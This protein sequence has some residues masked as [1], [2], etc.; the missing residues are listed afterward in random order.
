MAQRLWNVYGPEAADM[1]D[2]IYRILL[3]Q[4]IGLLKLQSILTCVRLGLEW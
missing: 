4:S 1:A 3:H 2:I